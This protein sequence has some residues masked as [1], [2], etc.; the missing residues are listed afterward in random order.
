M[1]NLG[2]FNKELKKACGAD[3]VRVVSKILDWAEDKLPRIEFGE[4]MITGYLFPLIER[5]GQKY[6][7]IALITDGIIQ[8]QFGQISKKPPFDDESLRRQFL[9]K[10]NAISGVSLPDDAIGR[11]PNIRLALLED[12]NAMAEFLAALE[13]YVT[14]VDKV[15][16]Q[17]IP[18]QSEE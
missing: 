14:Q 1:W 3:I 2:E 8:L 17:P 18:P 11:Y 10:L 9:E 13:W 15:F 16:D 7:P 5:G 12:A 6:C 4:G